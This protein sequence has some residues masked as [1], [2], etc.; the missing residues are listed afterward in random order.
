MHSNSVGVDGISL[1]IAKLVWSVITLSLCH[2]IYK[3]KGKGYFLEV[4]KVTRII[5]LV[6][7]GKRDGLSNKILIL[8]SLFLQ[9]IRKG[10]W[11]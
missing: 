4:L 7:E 8:F 1:K 10:Y 3:S 11:I 5:P 9:N 2:L 6:K